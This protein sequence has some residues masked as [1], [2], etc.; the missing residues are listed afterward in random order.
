MV[1]TTSPL[2]VVVLGGGFAGLETA[3]LL[4][5]RLRERVRVTLVSERPT[6]VSRP[7]TVYIPF[8]ADPRLL[9]LP[10]EEPSLRN[11]IAFV[12]ARALDV[13]PAR[14]LVTLSDR[15]LAYDKLVIATGAT[16]RPSEV[17]GL[18]DNGVKVWSPEDLVDLRRRLAL[19]IER[20]HN[21]RRTRMLF[22]VAPFNFCATP[23]YELLLMTDTHLRRAGLRAKVDLA[24][25]T[26]ERGYLQTFGP[27]LDALIADELLR[28]DIAGLRDVRLA[29]VTDHTVRMADGTV[30]GYEELVCFPPQIA[31]A[32]FAALPADDRGFIRCQLATRQVEGLPDVYA[33][34]DSG[35]FPVKH[36][37]LAFLEAD[38]AASHI[39]SQLTG[40]P[41]DA[42]FDPVSM[43]VIDGLDEAIFAQAPLRLTGDPHEPTTV[44]AMRPELYRV[45]HG[46]TW[47]VG[48]KLL[49]AYLPMRFRA[50]EPFHA[51][52]AWTMM[53]VGMKALGGLFAD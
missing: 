32:R 29:A 3:F 46:K 13:D 25:L 6:F 37:F 50:G 35:D 34:G 5:H 45:G 28:R 26:A 41:F 9:E 21:G 42:M 30:H 11:D 10:I 22:V 49:G 20:A 12:Q 16:T 8:G 19:T 14:K 4:H 17:H 1:T 38:A 53:D 39:A 51:G 44:D 15:T 33:P 18:D 48:K 36:A 24:L 27:R 47:R 7:S 40:R 23:M 31:K 43:A 2:H 52:A